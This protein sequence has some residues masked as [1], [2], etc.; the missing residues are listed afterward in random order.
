MQST[1]EKMSF[2][3]DNSNSLLPIISLPE[4]V[5]VVDSRLI[6]NELGVNHSD[7]FRNIILKYQNDCEADFGHLRFENGTVKNSVGAVNQVRFTHLTE[8]QALFFGVLSKNNKEVV[9]F[10]AKLVKS[11]ST[12]RKSLSTPMTTSEIVLW[13]AQRLVDIE[14]AQIEQA[15]ELRALQENQDATADRLHDVE[16]KIT[17]V[18]NDFYS[19]VGYYRLHGKQWDLSDTKAQQTGKNLKKMSDEFGYNTLSVNDAR[20]GKVLTYHVDVLRKYLGF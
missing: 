5:Q 20:Y 2:P 7:W 8:D 6:A 1:Q 17:N 18:N 14:K 9:A 11:F 19:L 16:A 3:N 13:N 15:E 4:G 12:F 10:K